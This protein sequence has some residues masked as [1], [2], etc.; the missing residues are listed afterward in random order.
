MASPRE[1]NDKKARFDPRRG[2]PRPKAP[3]APQGSGWLWGAHAAEAALANPARKILRVLAT[4]DRARSLEAAARG[5]AGPALR[6]E[7]ADNGDIARLLP[8]GAVHGG[9]AVLAADLPDADLDAMLSP[10]KGVI[11]VL[12]QV[13]DPQNVGA[14]LRSAAAFGVRGLIMQER[15][16]PE[17][18]GALAKA[19]AGAVERTPVAR[20]VNLSRALEAI[21]DAGWR[22]VGLAG[23]AQASLHDAVDGSPVALVLGSEGEG[24]RRLV[25]EHCDV[26]ARIPMPGGFESL[27]VS[28]AGAVALYEATRRTCAPPG[29]EHG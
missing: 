6:I 11:L 24:L 10:A 8:P 4:P 23:Q 19:A 9:V 5:R 18:S 2:G 17:L 16:S 1:R 3:A 14:L 20:V 26:L 27:N 28:A 21:A 13:T 29:G 12:D 7:A 15:H 25:A 22:T